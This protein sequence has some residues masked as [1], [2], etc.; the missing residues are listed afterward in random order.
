MQHNHLSAALY[1]LLKMSSEEDYNMVTN[2]VQNNRLDSLGHL[3]DENVEVINT[4]TTPDGR[5]LYKIMPWHDNGFSAITSDGLTVY[6]YTEATGWL[7]PIESPEFLN[8]VFPWDNACVTAALYTNT[9][10]FYED[11]QLKT[12]LSLNDMRGLE[13]MTHL[14]KATP[15]DDQRIIICGSRQDE[16][17]NAVVNLRT[18]RLEWTEKADTFTGGRIVRF[19]GF[20]V[21][22]DYKMLRIFKTNGK[23]ELIKVIPLERRA[24]LLPTSTGLLVLME[25]WRLIKYG[26]D[27][28]PIYQIDLKDQLSLDHYS[29][30]PTLAH[31]GNTSGSHLYVSCFHAHT[32]NKIRIGVHV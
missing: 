32:I 6:N 29:Y 2:W 18:Q 3:P 8:Y 10:S 20:D 23:R 28:K 17:F 1:G 7:S 22:V 4:L 27:F 15:I 30:S 14:N 25:N 13:G 16:M 5:S 26:M 19:N 21:A 12:T 24:V 31:G 9:L 11:N